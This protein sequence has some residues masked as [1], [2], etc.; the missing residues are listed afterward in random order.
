MW[1]NSL[2]VDDDGVVWLGSKDEGFV[3]Y[4]RQT[5]EFIAYYN[6]SKID[7]TERI[8]NVF[9][10]YKSNH[11]QQKRIWVGTA[12][13]GMYMLDYGLS[14]SNTPKIIHF[15]QSDFN[16]LGLNNKHVSSICEDKDNNIYVGTRTGLHKIILQEPLYDHLGRLDT[17]RIQIVTYKNIPRNTTSLSGNNIKA[18]FV[19]NLNRLWVGTRDHGLNML[20]EDSG[21]PDDAIFVRYYEDLDNLKGINSNNIQSI[22]EDSK[23]QLWIGTKGGGL[24]KFNSK[25]QTFTHYTENDGL[26]GSS[27]FSIL[28]DDKNNLWLGTNNGLARFNQNLPFGK[29]F[30]NYTTKDGL[31]GNAY[32]KEACY[33]DHNGALIFGGSEGMNIFFPDSIT[34]NL[35]VPGVKIVEIKILNNSVEP[36]EN[37]NG[38]IVLKQAIS[39]TKSILL[40]YKNYSISFEFVALSFI[41]HENNKYAYMLEGLD[42]DWIY[43][44]SKNRYANYSN[45]KRGNYVFK[46][47]A[48]NSD[49]IWNEEPTSLQIK[50]L[51]PPW[52]TIWAY[53]AYGILLSLILFLIR[54][55][56]LNRLKLQ[57]NLKYEKTER[58]KEDE[59]NQMKL[60]FFTNISHE[61]RTP[62]SLIISPVEDL[63]EEEPAEQ[64]ERKKK[65]D[66]ILRNTKSLFRLVNQFLDFRKAETGN[67]QLSVQEEN[68]VVFVKENIL[69][70]KELALKRH[71]KFE[72]ISNLKEQLL[73]FDLDK[74][75]KILFNLLSNAFKFTHDNGT[76]TIR[77]DSIKEETTEYIVIS[78]EDNGIGMSEEE[79]KQIFDR[80]YQ[81]N[82]SDDNYSGSGIGL[83]LIK[84]LV[85]LHFGKIEVSSEKD[86]GSKFTVYLQTGDKHF[87]HAEIHNP[88][89]VEKRVADSSY[90]AENAVVEIEEEQHIHIETHNP[91]EQENLIILIVE[92]N[93]DLRTC[94]KINLEHS[95]KILEATNGQEALNKIA[96]IIPD[97]IIT[98]LNMPVIDGL[99]LCKRLKSNI[100]TS[101]IPIIMLTARIE[102][103]HVIRGYETGA[104]AYISKP[105]NIK[106]LNVRVQRLFQSINEQRENFSRSSLML[107]PET[108]RTSADEKY[109]E[110]VIEIIEKNIQNSEFNVK[111]LVQEM[112]TSNSML[113]R[114]LKA[115]TNLSPN[116]FIRTIRLKKAAQILEQSSLSVNEVAYAVGF[117]SPK[118]F[119][120]CFQKQ[121][122]RKI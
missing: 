95:Y 92:D 114:K 80:Y 66:L 51:P 55:I 49:D 53:I 116:E 21:N 24:N 122:N 83:A 2:C 109:L 39:D 46:V 94:I 58:V 69:P 27:V 90:Q 91:D 75:E 103:E 102:I 7:I 35:I 33:K 85:Q 108:T 59:I 32:S 29:Q 34:D 111:N 68:I 25:N 72:Y 81:A 117:N 40:N 67:L 48:S 119:R 6:D 47:K 113:Y 23:N 107:P 77:L 88:N 38:D 54:V 13:L 19:D 97:L 99:E 14:M 41:N 10:I 96:K 93:I 30:R 118:Y 60:R 28:E 20:Q 84:N 43:T 36:Y 5:N 78:I 65:Y 89:I 52:A 31:Q 16:Q 101:H 120:Q 45:L 86:K 56:V 22:F 82:T 76:I 3:K 63:L 112:V 50:V 57:A 73:W 64:S 115:F 98:D 70:F 11:K 105:F 37:I 100:E 15:P 79:K 110:R 26:P 44:D 1:I 4:N 8:S 74:L 121:F 87:D 12:L 62:L 42:E 17:A 104:D 18:V 106:Y 61:F 9:T 71:I